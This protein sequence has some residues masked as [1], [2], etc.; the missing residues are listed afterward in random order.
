M[1]IFFHFDQ[2]KR[3]NATKQPAKFLITTGTVKKDDT[4]DKVLHD[5]KPPCLLARNSLDQAVRVLYTEPKVRHF[6]ANSH[7]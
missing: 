6:I 7:I 2:A 3:Y 1:E 5:T 4:I